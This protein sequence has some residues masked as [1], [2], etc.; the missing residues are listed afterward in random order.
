VTG[1]RFRY[2]VGG[3]V[4]LDPSLT[5]AEKVEA[6]VKMLTDERARHRR[7]RIRWSQTLTRITTEWS[8]LFDECVEVVE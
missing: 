8:D 3:T 2:E 5:D 7:A 1:R 6:L 4:T